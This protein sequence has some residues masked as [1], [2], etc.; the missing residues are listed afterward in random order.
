[1]AHAPAVLRRP[2]DARAHPAVG[3]A[4]RPEG[5]L[6][7]GGAA[8]GVS[9]RAHHLQPGAVVAGPAGGV[10]GGP[11][12]RPISRAELEARRRPHRRRR[13]VHP[14]EL[15]P[16]A[17]PADDRSLSALR[18]AAGPSRRAGDRRPTRTPR[19]G[20]SAARTCATCRCG[21]SWRGSIRSTWTATRACARSSPRA[22][23][24]TEED[25][26]VL[27][28]PSSWRSSTGSFR[29]TATP[30]PAGR[31][32]CR[33]LRSTIRFCRCCATRTS[34]FG[35]IPTR[36]SL[37]SDSSIPRTRSSNWSAPSR[38]TG[39]YSGARRSACGRPKARCPTR[40]R[41]WPPP[42]GSHGWRP[43]S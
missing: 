35:R 34:I 16:R 27:R 36:E 41:R 43:T 39:V 19:P 15:L 18:G 42:P 25:K 13:G 17:A 37:A 7:D 10:C 33:R 28:E 30:P 38:C 8:A 5:L 24:F 2:G 40:W 31:S 11:G 26:A 23:D 32:S 6:R 29:S 21:T 9:R 14:R 22:A 3:P 1:M 4:A 12:A 20:A